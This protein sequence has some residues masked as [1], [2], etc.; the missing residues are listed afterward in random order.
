MQSLIEEAYAGLRVSQ[1]EIQK[2]LR[3]DD[4]R[5]EKH[6]PADDAEKAR[7]LKEVESV[8]RQIALAQPARVEKRVQDR[9][10]VQRKRDSALT[11]LNLRFAV[12]IVLNAIS[13]AA[14]AAVA[15]LSLGT[16]AV[17]LVGAAKTLVSTAMLIKDFAEGRDKAAQE[18]YALD[19]ALWKIYIGPRMKDTAFRTAEEVA[20]AIGVP[21][22]PSV[23]KLASRLE[24]FLGKSARIDEQRQKIYEQANKLLASVAKIDAAKA[25]AENAKKLAT[26]GKHVTALLDRLHELARS[27]AGDDAFHQRYVDRIEAYHALD[28]RALSAA[29]AVISFGALAAGIALTA[30]SIVDV[31][32]TLA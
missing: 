30:K 11:R 13:L 15:A 10:E 5:Y 16:L 4:E 23:G 20:S 2:A 19:Q 21:F 9:W 6:P 27:I 17:T 12:Q 24:D 25:G 18:V 3:D 26:L 1:K 28:G 22:V 7:R 14:S 32:T 31:A 8:C 29:P